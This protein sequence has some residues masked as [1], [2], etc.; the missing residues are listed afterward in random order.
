MLNSK[1]LKAPVL[2]SDWPN[3]FVISFS[4]NN[5]LQQP[6][7]ASGVLEY[8]MKH[9]GELVSTFSIFQ[10]EKKEK[11][12]KM[13]PRFSDNKRC[14]PM[15]WFAIN[16]TAFFT[17]GKSKEFLDNQ[18]DHT[19]QYSHTLRPFYFFKQFWTEYVFS[20]L[21]C[22]KNSVCTS[23][24]PY[25]NVGVMVVWGRYPQ[26]TMILMCCIWKSHLLHVSGVYSKRQNYGLICLIKMRFACS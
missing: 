2:C 7:A 21:H 13:C 22:I 15:P 16:S 1:T 23:S 26:N 6:E 18:L 20:E 14:K 17:S 25:F 4:I 3:S 19:G 8:A 24:F 5:K 10:P 11:R 12:R 9:F